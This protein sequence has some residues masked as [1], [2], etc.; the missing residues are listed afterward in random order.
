[1]GQ[2]LI[3]PDFALLW[4]KQSVTA[5]CDALFGTTLLIWLSARTNSPFSVGL[6]FVA[7]GTPYAL[8]GPFAEAATERWSRRRTMFVTDVVR[9]LLTFLLCI[10]VL[11]VFTPRRA[12]AVIYLLCFC[13]GL[14]SRFSLAAQRSAITAVVPPREHARGVSR[15]QGSAAIMTIAGPILAAMLFLLV[16]PSPL[17]GLILAGFLLL[18]S[19]GGAQ[20]M[21]H[22]FTA[23][24]RAVQARRKRR[25]APEDEEGEQDPA[26]EEDEEEEPWTPSVLRGGMADGIKGVR[27]VLRQRPFG[28]LASIVALVALVGGIFNI[29]EVFFVSTYL[30]YPGAYLGLIV[31]ANAAGVLL[32]SVWFRQLDA[33][34]SPVTTFTYAVLGMGLTT[35][36]FISSRSLGI[37]I[38]WAAAMGLTNG[39][40]LLAAQ[41]ALVETGERKY[42]A[43]LFVGYE[44]LT[45]LLGTIGAFLGSAA[46]NF[47]SIGAVLGAASGLLILVGV[48]AWLVLSGKAARLKYRRAAAQAAGEQEEGFEPLDETSEGY[49]PAEDEAAG[50]ESA[51]FDE[52]GD[53]GQEQAPP[54]YRP[55]SR[56]FGRLWANGAGDQYGADDEAE[57]SPYAESAE[58]DDADQWE[59][60]APVEEP[61]APRRTLRLRPAPWEHSGGPGRSR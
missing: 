24:V 57:E 51:D 11:P 5:L 13:I 43:R 23:K 58:P 3:S 14:M 38:L 8:F 42:L 21:D 19:A 61:P 39:M 29:L 2:I 12:L 49:E 40:I 33:H 59:P 48:G 44:T 31:S 55:P 1:M 50:D 34:L 37:A 41:T 36:G 35:A 22:Q 20:A 6:A 17:P 26:R 28:T 7:L 45:A 30:G 10:T 25:D 53:E 18:L 56:Q 60:A 9:G 4:L 15:I 32:G 46:A 47:I 16:G 54:M 52:A 27:R